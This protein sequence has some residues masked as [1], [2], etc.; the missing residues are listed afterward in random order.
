M[1]IREATLGDAL[2]IARVHVDSWR[3][4][5][6]GIVADDYLAKLSYEQR[7]TVWKRN[8]T[9]PGQGTEKFTLV[10][11][12][13]YGAIVAFASGGPERERDPIY[14]GE[15]WAIYLLAEVQRAG[16]GR[17]LVAEVAA[18][19]ARAGRTSMLVWVLAGN[20]ACRFYERLG[21]REVRRKNVILE[22]QA[23]EHI[24]YG[25]TDTSALFAQK[26]Q[27]PPQPQPHHGP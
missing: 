7:E 13:S 17:R 10:A 25:W 19:L 20:P 27:P 8:L 2:G 23:L 14:T 16:I 9:E 21:G 4:T 12:D 6:A 26:Y 24:A 5:Y 18:R 11:E 3:S 1:L 15:L 22:S